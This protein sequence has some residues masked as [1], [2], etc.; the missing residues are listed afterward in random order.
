MT[1]HWKEE[2]ERLA[3]ANRKLRRELET[4]DKAHSNT[5]GRWLV[6]EARKE[7]LKQERKGLRQRVELLTIAGDEGIRQRNEAMGEVARVRVLLLSVLSQIKEHGNVG[8]YTIMD[9][10]QVLRGGDGA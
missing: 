9:I 10:E 5:A 4:Q 3:A 2:A 7:D 6:A 1:D 8:I